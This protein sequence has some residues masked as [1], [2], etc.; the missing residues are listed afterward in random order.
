[1]WMACSFY[2]TR[3]GLQQ[4]SFSMIPGRCLSEAFSISVL[5]CIEMGFSCCVLRRLFI[6]PF[7]ISVLICIEWG[8][9]RNSRFSRFLQIRAFPVL[10]GLYVVP[11]VLCYVGFYCCFYCLLYCQATFKS[12]SHFLNKML[13]FDG[14]I[15]WKIHFSLCSAISTGGGLFSMVFRFRTFSRFWLAGS[16]PRAVLRFQF[17]MSNPTF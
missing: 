2:F 10:G 1:M 8:F 3:E 16:L 9:S 4:A 5:I 7:L 12:I 13:I 14:S 6:D 15:F 11:F 17:L